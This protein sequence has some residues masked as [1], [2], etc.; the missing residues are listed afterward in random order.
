MT[1]IRGLSV[2]Q[3]WAWAIAYA[4]KDV[5]NR[6]RRTTYRG[7]LAIHASLTVEHGVLMPTPAA[8]RKHLTAQR[9]QDP[10]PQVTGAII[11]VAE[12]YGCHDAPQTGAGC[13]RSAIMCS[14]WALEGQFHWQLRMVRPLP[15]PV[16][17]KGALG[18][19]H[20]PDAAHA[21]IRAQLSG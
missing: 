2:R 11:A 16:P 21:A 12:L 5:E 13:S 10:R 7:L 17:C 1:E 18:L 8:I 15:M 14:P 6:S 9:D 20:L 3:P 19:W 4:G